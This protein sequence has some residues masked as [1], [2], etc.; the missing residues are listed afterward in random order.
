MTWV[1]AIPALHLDKKRYLSVRQ[2][3]FIY[4]LPHGNDFWA[5]LIK[6]ISMDLPKVVIKDSYSDYLSGKEV[7]ATVVSEKLHVEKGMHVMGFHNSIAVNTAFSVPKEKQSHYIGV[8]GMV[9]E[10]NQPVSSG[11]KA[12]KVKV[13]KI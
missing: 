7:E 1:Q 3:S 12:P 2:V 4:S 10:I 11:G 8:E 13:V 6:P 5:F 9:T